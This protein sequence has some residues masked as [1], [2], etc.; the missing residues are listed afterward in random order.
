M[1]LTDVKHRSP[2]Q[3]RPDR[4]ERAVICAPL[5][6]LYLHVQNT[7]VGPLVSFCGIRLYDSTLDLLRAG[8]VRMPRRPGVVLAY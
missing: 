6:F 4:R 2:H 8:P 1:V 7:H 3:R 5:Y